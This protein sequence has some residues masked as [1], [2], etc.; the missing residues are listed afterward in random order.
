MA[1]TRLLA[2]LHPWFRETPV[3]HM[4]SRSEQSQSLQSA[5]PRPAQGAGSR[6]RSRVSRRHTAVHALPGTPQCGGPA[7]CQPHCCSSLC[8]STVW[9]LS[10]QARIQK[11]G[12]FSPSFIGTSNQKHLE[13]QGAKLA[14][15]GAAPALPGPLSLSELASLR[16]LS[17]HPPLQDGFPPACLASSCLSSIIHPLTSSFL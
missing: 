7:C 14:A 11:G 4:R 10:E 3:S 1:Y 15:Q 17:Q 2:Y 6:P 16:P 9:V 13:I 12:A 8:Y 5:P